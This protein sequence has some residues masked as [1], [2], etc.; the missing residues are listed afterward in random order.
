MGC[1]CTRSL[2]PLGPLPTRRFTLFSWIASLGVVGRGFHL[3]SYSFFSASVAFGDDRSLSQRAS[4]SIRESWSTFFFFFFGLSCAS[5]PAAACR[6]RF[7]PYLETL[8]HF[9]FASFGPTLIRETRFTL[10]GGGQRATCRLPSLLGIYS[11][12]SLA[13][14]AL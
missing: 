11:P 10:F 1:T 8:F 7:C 13:N 5:M 9:H 12:F 14:S 3:A 2:R 6:V 4:T